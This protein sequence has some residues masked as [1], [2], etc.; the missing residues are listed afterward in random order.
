MAASRPEALTIGLVHTLFNIFGIV[1]LYGIPWLRPLPIK[2]AE[3]LADL[4]V[5][6]RMIAIGYVGVTFILV[7][8]IGLVFFL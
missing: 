8:L 7:P 1:I 4:A 6:R 3:T 5:K 2:A